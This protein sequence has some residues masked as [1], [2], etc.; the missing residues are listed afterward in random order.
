MYLL[1]YILFITELRNKDTKLPQLDSQLL[2]LINDFR[3]F[4]QEK[5]LLGKKFKIS[6]QYM[7]DLLR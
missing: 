3:K 5:N 7:T 2:N 4:F 6:E 1:I